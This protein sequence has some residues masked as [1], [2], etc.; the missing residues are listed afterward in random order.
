MDKIIQLNVN[1]TTDRYP[2]PIQ[3]KLGGL[4]TTTVVFSDDSETT[5]TCGAG[6][7]YDV[8]KAIYAA[9]AKRFTSISRI[10]KIAKSN[11]Y[12]KMPPLPI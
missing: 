10:K 2:Q 9:V 4:K 5:V 6:E 7:N 3:I 12:C 8:E 11:A 1:T